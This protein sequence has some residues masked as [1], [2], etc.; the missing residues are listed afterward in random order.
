[1]ALVT[2]CGRPS[3]R[4]EHSAPSDPYRVR[5]TGPERPRTFDGARNLDFEI[6][7]GNIKQGYYVCV[8]K[9]MVTEKSGTSAARFKTSSVTWC[10]RN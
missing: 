2:D 9:V 1:V 3:F 5:N 8:L 10:N 4:D 6:D 7:I